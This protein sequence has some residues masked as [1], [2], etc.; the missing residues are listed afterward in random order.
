M[1]H[2][3]HG[4]RIYP[5]DK[6]KNNNDKWAKADRWINGLEFKR[7]FNEAVALAKVGTISFGIPFVIQM[8]PIGGKRPKYAEVW[9]VNP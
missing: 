7:D 4:Y 5:D 8:N 2:N 6:I 3:A 9:V 1:S